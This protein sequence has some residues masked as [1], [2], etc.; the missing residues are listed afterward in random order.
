MTHKL[1]DAAAKGEVKIDLEANPMG[2]ANP[3]QTPPKESKNPIHL[4]TSG[5]VFNQKT[6]N[7]G[8][9]Q[10]IEFRTAQASGSAVGA[11]Y[12]ANDRILTLESQIDINAVPAECMPHYGHPRHH[13]Q[14]PAEY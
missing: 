10:R 12:A 7:A 4:R 14:R 13:Y 9:D 6:G 5:L 1:G 2:V 3:D 8:T 11:R